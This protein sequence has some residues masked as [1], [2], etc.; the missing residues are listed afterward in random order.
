MRMLNLAAWLTVATLATIVAFTVTSNGRIGWDESAPML[1][2]LGVLYVV[3]VAARA[4][5]ARKAAGG[6]PA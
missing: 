4:R 3:L 2:A 5:A 6:P 1:V